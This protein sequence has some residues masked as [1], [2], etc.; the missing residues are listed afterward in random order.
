M[1][2]RNNTDFV[3]N[4]SAEAYPA[5]VKV[6]PSNTT[7]NFAN[8]KY[9]SY[10]DTSGGFTFTAGVVDNAGNYTCTASNGIVTDSLTY[11][12]FVGGEREWEG[13]REEG[14]ESVSDYVSKCVMDCHMYCMYEYECN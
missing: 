4:C 5:D 6:T 13:G 8:V 11:Q 10:D 12:V 2:F 3:V 9:T 7:D 1:E 14:R